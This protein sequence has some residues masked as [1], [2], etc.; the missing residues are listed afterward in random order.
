[1]YSEEDCS[2]IEKK[3]LIR[4]L[5][6]YITGGI[7]LA[8]AILFIVMSVRDWGGYLHRDASGEETVNRLSTHIKLYPLSFILPITAGA[9]LIFGIGVFVMPVRSYR[10]YIK[11]AVY[12]KTHS[13]SCFF[14]SMDEGRV[15]RD[16]VWVLPVTVSASN[17]KKEED[18]RQ[19]YL[20]ELVENPG[21]R[22]GDPLLL[23]VHDKFIV[24][25][26]RSEG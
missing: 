7:L 12:G 10:N 19:L 6:V 2:K 15:L 20:D 14:K 25:F 4:R 1:M 13:L 8:A 21:W 5:A 11:Q 23:T 24:N 18:D 22:S 9:V 16:G 17:M 3:L 26:E